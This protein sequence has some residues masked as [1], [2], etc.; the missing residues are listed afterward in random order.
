MKKELL[1]GGL[2]AGLLFTGCA[3][4]LGDFTVASTKNV[5][6]LKTDPVTHHVK[7]ESCIH[8]VLFLP[9]GNFNDRIKEAMD[10]AIDNGRKKGYNGDL[11]LNTRIYHKTWTTLIYGQDCIIV[12][13]DLT[14]IKK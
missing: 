10:D 11:L 8:Y 13:G 4:R 2:V 7:G 6:N 14:K 12:E 1:L 3:Q 5:A 9:F